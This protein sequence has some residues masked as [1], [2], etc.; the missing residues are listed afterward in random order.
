MEYST[1]QDLATTTQAWNA[2]R[3]EAINCAPYDMHSLVDRVLE[4]WK[5]AS[6]AY[7][8][9]AYGQLNRATSRSLA[10]ALREAE[11]AI[12]AVVSA[13]LPLYRDGY[14][15]HRMPELGFAL[16]RCRLLI[17]LPIAKRMAVRDD[18]GRSANEIASIL[19]QKAQ[20]IDGRAVID[21]ALA[22]ELPSPFEASGD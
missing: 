9:M 12:F 8:A 22:S 18:L 16:M 19:V 3:E 11:Q 10:L 17:V 7:R 4:R 5:S 6:I 14:A 15:P 1:T 13:A 20:F 2:D 21:Q